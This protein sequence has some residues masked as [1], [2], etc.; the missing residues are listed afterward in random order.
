MEVKG[1]GSRVIAKQ[2]VLATFPPL[3]ATSFDL[4]VRRISFVSVPSRWT[5]ARADTLDTPA[6]LFFQSANPHHFCSRQK[7][8][9]RR[10]SL[11]PWRLLTIAVPRSHHAP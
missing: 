2:A 1:G 8:R 4:I 7:H 11:I 9:L 3:A 10:A 6:V 5:D